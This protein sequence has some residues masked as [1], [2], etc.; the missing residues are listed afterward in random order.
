MGWNAA[1]SH[2]ESQGIAENTEWGSPLGR[3]LNIDP[4]TPLYETDPNVLSQAPYTSGGVLR[5]NLVRDENGIFAIS[6]RVTSEIVNPVAAYN[7]ANGIGWS[8]KFVNNT[9]A[10]I[11]LLEG[12]EFKT[13]M[14]IDLAFWGNDGLN[15]PHYLNATNYHRKIYLTVS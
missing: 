13:S 1:Y 9:Y 7:L 15:V 10:A 4:I 2:S 12:L 6:P 11:R 5:S 14:G 3:A 8:D